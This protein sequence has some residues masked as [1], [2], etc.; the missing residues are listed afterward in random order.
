MA[1]AK[2]RIKNVAVANGAKNYHCEI[3]GI[4]LTIN[5]SNYTIITAHAIKTKK[6]HMKHKFID[7]SLRANFLRG[8]FIHKFTQ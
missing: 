5:S 6:F 1:K 4:R 3:D 7:L 8:K 2:S